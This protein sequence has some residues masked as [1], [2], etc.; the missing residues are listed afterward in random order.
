MTSAATPSSSVVRHSER[1]PRR[2]ESAFDFPAPQSLITAHDRDKNGSAASLL[3]S[4]LWFARPALRHP[5]LQPRV[6]PRAPICENFP[7]APHRVF[8]LPPRHAPR[9][10]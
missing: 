8:L 1:S 2:V 6:F 7:A 5:V 10:P 9:N 4:A 3:F